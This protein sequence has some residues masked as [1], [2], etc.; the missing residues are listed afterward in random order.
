MY[1][2][3]IIS[4]VL[5]TKKD[6]FLTEDEVY[7]LLYSSGVSNARPA[8]FSGK[9]GRKVIFLSYEDEIET[10]DPAIRKP[11]YLWSGKQVSI[12]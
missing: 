6:T 9:A 4:A 10:V 7:Q 1:Q 11:I 12:L 5:L 2:D 8:S 3:H